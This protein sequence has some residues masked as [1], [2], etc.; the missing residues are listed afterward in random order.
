MLSKSGS[1]SL[2]QEAPAK[3]TT[4]PGQL[5][6]VWSLV[7]FTVLDKAG[8]ILDFP[9]GRHPEGL[10]IYT[11]DGFISVHLSK[12]KRLAHTAQTEVAV[13]PGRPP[14]VEAVAS[15]SHYLGYTGTYEWRG[16]LVVHHV[17]VASVPQWTGT[18]QVRQVE[19]KRDVL[20]LRPPHGA[21]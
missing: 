7:S 3:S 15:T 11:A 9:M 8:S 19:L 16:D 20:T 18:Q 13:G 1:T 17:L 2:E 10:L 14:E 5:V 6:G 12:S 21:C 4:G